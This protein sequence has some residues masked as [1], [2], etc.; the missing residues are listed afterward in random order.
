MRVAS[1]NKHVRLGAHDKESRAERK[2]KEPLKIDVNPDH[3]VEGA[4]LRHDL[5]EDL[6][7]MHIPASDTDEGGNVPVQ[8]QQSAHLA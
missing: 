2:N 3:Y 8:V 7:I 6:H 1:L 4:S 5:V